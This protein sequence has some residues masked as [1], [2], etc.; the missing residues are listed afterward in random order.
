MRTAAGTHHTTINLSGGTFHTVDMGP[1][2]GG[3][4]GTNSILPDGADWGWASSLPA[5]LATSPGPG[6]VTFAPEDGAT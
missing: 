4:L 3:L 1:N 5:T 6:V 2:T